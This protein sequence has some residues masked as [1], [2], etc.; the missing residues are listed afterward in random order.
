MR[1]WWAAISGVTA[2]IGNDQQS[3]WLQGSEV[4]DGFHAR[5]AS[6]GAYLNAF[7]L[8]GSGHTYLHA[9]A[10]HASGSFAL[11]GEYNGTGF[12]PDPWNSN[13]LCDGEGVYNLFVA[14]YDDVSTL[15][16]APSEA[17]VPGISPMP[18]PHGAVV[19]VSLERGTMQRIELCATTGK[20]V[21]SFTVTGPSAVIPLAGTA[22]GL[23]LVRV[24]TREGLWTTGKLIV[25]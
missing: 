6:D 2:S 16:P 9:L 13:T 4:S 7:A 24:Y 18:A 8:H 17:T 10:T 21:S 25:E 20:Q 3:G 19:R 15:A 12:D 11:G 23:Y 1:C 5:L 22:P 14:Q